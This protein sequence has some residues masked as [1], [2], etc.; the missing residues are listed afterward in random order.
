[1]QDDLLELVCA[2]YNHAMTDAQDPRAAF[3]QAVEMVKRRLRLLTLGGAQRVVSQI[4]E[5]ERVLGE[6]R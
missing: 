2:T 1:M 5:V 4:V 6:V 3:E